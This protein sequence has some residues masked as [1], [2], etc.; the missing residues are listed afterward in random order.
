MIEAFLIDSNT[1]ATLQRV[2][3]PS[4]AYLIPEDY[5]ADRAFVLFDPELGSIDDFETELDGEAVLIVPR[6]VDPAEQLAVAKINALA[7]VKALRDAK[8]GGGC[9]TSFGRVDTDLSSRLNIAGAV[10]MAAIA[11]AAFS[12]EWRMS[13][14]SVVTLDGAQMTGMGVAVGQFVAACQARKNVLDAEIQAAATL[15][16]LEL[17][18][19]EAG[20]P[21]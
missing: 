12:V 5:G 16:E 6:T 18:D 10:S 20:W 2:M 15:A 1:G 19:V 21:E 3:V 14:N 17:I 7:A 8:Q 4:Q 13:D 9:A 11:G